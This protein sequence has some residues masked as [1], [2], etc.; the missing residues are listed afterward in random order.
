MN[1]GNEKILA[2]INSEDFIGRTR[3]INS[4][5]LHSK[6][7]RRT[8]ALLLN[9]APTVGASELLSQIYDRMFVENG[10]VIPF[11]FAVKKSDKTAKQCAVRFLQT[12]LA[13]TIAFR[14]QDTTIFDN[15]PEICE[16]TEL[17][18]PSDGYWI[19]RIVDSCLRESRLN[20][21]R[22]FVRQA[23]SAP[24]RG[25]ANHARFFVMIDNLHEAE[26]FSDEPNFIEELNEIYGRSNINFVFA[27]HRRFI[28]EKLRGNYENLALQSLS[29]TEAG[30]LAENLAE[31]YEV[32]ISEQTRDLIALRFSA[33]PLFVKNIF[34]KASE[35]DKDLSSFQRVEQINAEELFGGRI[36]KFYDSIFNE[37]SPNIETQKNF[38]GLLYDALTL[39]KDKSPIEAW[40]KRSGLNAEGFYRAIRFLNDNE[41]VRISSN[42]VETSEENEILNDYIKTRFRLE[43]IEENRALVFGEML[44]EFLKRAPETMAKFYRKSSAIG[45]RELLSVFDCQETPLALLDYE[46]FKENFKGKPDEE[47]LGEIEKEQAN[48]LLPQI[49]YTAHTVAFYPPLKQFSEKERS[50]IALGFEE[51]VYTT[52]G[53]IVWLAAEIDSKLEA[54]KEVTE[55]WCDR[56]EMVALMCNFPKNQLWLVAPEGFSPEALEVLRSRNAFGSSKKQ[57]ELLVNY[58]K[59]E[60]AIGKKTIQN[61]YE[62]IVPMGE[63]TELIAA[64][65]IEEIARR[66]HFAPKA[67]N[68]I[69]TALVEACINATEHSLS[70]DRK[71]YQKFAVEDDKI[72]I[73]ISNRGLRL[74]EKQAQEITPNEGRRGWGLNLMRTLMDEVKLEQVDD[75]TRISMTKYLK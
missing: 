60:D 33:N 52:E 35:K 51:S 70:P 69:K 6:G 57:V 39:E 48:V 59:A 53:E 36:G 46:R 73:T 20:N 65:T 25:V 45:L 50:A 44:S 22:A 62:M 3:E 68:Q 71:I 55:F 58:L 32:K 16:L 2:S 41:I 28:Y 21:D 23:L 24:L 26:N 13:Q 14:R 49:V 37:I 66:H 15:S 63:D 1:L 9:C 40:Q 47:I 42:L 56:L 29:F 74:A 72:T 64:Q 38:L 4:L 8:N 31:K 5:L 12:F 18:L 30:M 34:Q 7:E 75:G 27:G 11:Y 17:V 10:D 61:E 54:N 43:T 19:D 67:I